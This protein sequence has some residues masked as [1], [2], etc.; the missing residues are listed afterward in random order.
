MGPLVAMAIGYVVGARTGRKGLDDMVQAAKA[1][2]RS[3]EFA[4][5]VAVTRTHL[6]GAMRELATVVERGVA[7]DEIEPSADLVERVRSIVGPR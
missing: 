5:L 6:A 4:D 3:E 2:V 1:V 7:K